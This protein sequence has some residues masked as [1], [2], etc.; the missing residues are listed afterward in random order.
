MPRVLATLL[1]Y[2]P[3][4]CACGAFVYF[5]IHRDNASFLGGLILAAML[6]PEVPEK[7]DD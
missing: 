5:A 7:N 6:L 3:A 1:A 4:L 2:V